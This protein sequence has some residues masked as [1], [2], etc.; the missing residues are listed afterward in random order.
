MKKIILK[1]PMIITLS[2]IGAICGVAIIGFTAKTILSKK[3]SNENTVTEDGLIPL[4]QDELTSNTYYAKKKDGTFYKLPEGTLFIDDDSQLIATHADPTNRLLAF[5]NDDSSIPTIY[6]DETIAYKS[7]DGTEQNSD[8]TVSIPSIFY[9]ERFKDEGY[10]LGIH[11][12]KSDKDID[13]DE[14]GEEVDLSAVQAGMSKKYHATVTSFIFCAGSDFDQKIS[15]PEG[16]QLII[17]KVGGVPLSENNV[18]SGGTIT[19]LKKDNVYKADVY[20][21]TTYIG[22]DIKAD[23]HMM[24]SYE[25]Y[26][27]DDYDMNE[28]N[29]LTISM[30][31]D[32]WSGYYF[33]NGIG[34]FKYI[35]H[36]AGHGSDDVELNTPYILAED[37]ETGELTLNPANGKQATK[38]TGSSENATSDPDAENAPIASTEIPIESSD[39]FTLTFTYSSLNDA[40]AITPT[41]SLVDPNGTT[42]DFS[43]DP[44]E[45]NTLSVHITTVTPGTW[46]LNMSGINNRTWSTKYI[47]TQEAIP[48]TVAES[49]TESTEEA[50]EAEVITAPTDATN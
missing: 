48:E 10:S 16:D 35:N 39:S 44:N 33:V 24:T 1:K 18:S 6:S 25:L 5:L 29:Y 19:G 50:E 22:T 49:S 47:K 31:E 37:P 30:P 26:T 12:L 28:G 20:D 32:M 27:I 15:A 13:G 41:V 46:T 21:G 23:T 17:D 34:A 9:F 2:V 11:G 38:I 40:S 45:Q 4:T 42:Y 14:T 3:N 7:P 43:E 36:P 8:G